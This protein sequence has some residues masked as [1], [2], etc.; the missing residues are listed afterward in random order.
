MSSLKLVEV[1]SAKELKLF[2]DFP[3]DLYEGDSCYVPE[4]YMAQK[5]LLN[6]KKHPFY[7]Y[8]DVVPIIAYQGEK[9]V[10]RIAAIK[11]PAYN[12]YH[13]SKIGFFGFY[14]YIDSE[15]VA[16]VLLDKVKEKL[17]SE[18]YEKL[19]GPVNFST[20]ETAGTLVEGFDSPPKVMMTYN[21]PYYDTIQKKIGL[22]KEMDLF[23]F[24]IPTVEASDRS[25]KLSR[26]IEERLQGQGISIRN[27][28]I[29]KIKQEVPGLRKAYNQAWEKNWGFVPM[30]E[31]E[32]DV[33]AN[34]LKLIADEDFAYV[35]EHE[36]RIVGFSVSLPDVN[37]ITKDFKKGRLFPF[38]II[39]LLLRKNKVKSVRI[40]STGVIEGFRK[41]GIEAIFFAKN[42]QAA[43]ERKLDG[44]EASWVLESNKEMVTA[45]EKL[46]GKKYKTYR[47]YTCPA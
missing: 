23:A 18:D 12:S 17:A 5:D 32:F 1:S 44:G 24:F 26:I 4:L 28:N 45:A 6:K 2:I 25:I 14:D 41:K 15:E 22:S 27:L 19:M 21:K 46:N 3:H 38:N 37:E 30:N 8:G 34:D 43:R 40:I 7:E 11:N 13:N 16:R 35:A 42:I 20:N 33:L 10:G 29:K 39:K 9:I 31:K 36:G 47:L